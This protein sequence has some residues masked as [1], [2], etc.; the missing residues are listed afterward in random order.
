MSFDAER[1]AALLNLLDEPDDAVWQDIREKLIELGED[2][3]PELKKT[4]ENTFS[5]VLKNRLNGLI[6]ALNFEKGSREI[7]TW[8]LFGQKSLLT[9]SLIIERAFNPH[10]DEEY[11]LKQLESIRFDIWLELNQSLSPLEKIRVFN[12]ILFHV[13]GFNR[14][15]GNKPDSLPPLLSNTLEHRT[16]NEFASS[17]L[18]LLLALE[19]GLP[20]KGFLVGKKLFLAYTNTGEDDSLQFLGDNEPLFFIDPSSL[21][22][23]LSR[24]DIT[25]A[26]SSFRDFNKELKKHL[27][28]SKKIIQ[29]QLLLLYSFY[30]EEGDEDRSV[31]AKELMEVLKSNS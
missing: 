14:Y 24:Q 8:C 25:D 30:S 19:T 5:P 7:K 18:Y 20:V 27:I 29:L 3:L 11:Y 9:G 31:L 2:V 10:I 6:H 22:L 1:L 28:S 4:F 12:Q 23:V 21:G 15:L 26:F 16:G 13:Y 17:L